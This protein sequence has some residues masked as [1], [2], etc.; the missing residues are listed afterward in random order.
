MPST[1]LK[2]TSISALKAEY[3]R[4]AGIAAS[5]QQRF[6]FSSRPDMMRLVEAGIAANRAREAWIDALREAA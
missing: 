1:E 6:A 5:E 4:L 2:S 3:L